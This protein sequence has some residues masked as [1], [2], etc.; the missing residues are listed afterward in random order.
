MT[1]IQRETDPNS[2]NNNDN[3][4]DDDFIIVDNPLDN[5]KDLKTHKEITDALK[6]KLIIDDQEVSQ[7]FHS[8][9]N[10]YVNPKQAVNDYNQY[11]IN[12][13]YFPGGTYSVHSAGKG[14]I[15][16]RIEVHKR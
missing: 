4:G 1:T 2:N 3:D 5:F 11:S 12:H 6:A 7:H 16:E 14:D 9:D 15:G 13:N 10:G 8:L